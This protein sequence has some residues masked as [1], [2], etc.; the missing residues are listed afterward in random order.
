MTNE[1]KTVLVLTTSF[2]VNENIGAGIHVLG[3]CKQLVK[4]GWKVHVLAP[5]H[6]RSKKFEV[7]EGI[8]VKRFSYF[9]PERY[10]KVA[11]GSGM[12]NNLKESTLAKIQLPF[13]FLSFLVNAIIY[14]KKCDIVHAHWFPAG[15]I[16]VFVKKIFN[17]KL[18][19]MMHHP[20]KKNIIYK[21]ILKNT[22][23]L[24]ANS[25]YVLKRTDEIFETK[26]KA[27]LPVPIDYNQFK[28]DSDLRLIRRKHNIPDDFIF[29]F[30]AGRFINWKGFEYLIEAI[31]LL[32]L[33][34]SI[35]NISLKIAGQGPNFKKYQDLINEKDIYKYVELIGYIPNS[36]MPN[37]YNEAD[38][39]VIPSIIDENGETEGFGVVSLE[40]NA[41]R[42]PV[43]GSKVGGIVDV[44]KDGENGFLVEQKN[45]EDLA[46]KL[47]KLI[48]NR[49]QREK[50]GEIGCE[51]VKNKFNWEIVGNKISDVYN[52][53]I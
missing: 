42:T 17:M 11:Y 29:I 51:M 34:Y 10:Q 9:F 6:V 41:C 39:F 22:D 35:L 36:E 13:F 32:V 19:L 3:K 5:S 50:M 53:L 23:F 31:N 15:L 24:F 49:S 7:I 37:Y 30:S 14:G 18:V 45:A 27:I 12:P 8:N 43:V 25:S 4:N 2:P 20:H 1:T 38:I 44:I 48:M 52:D 40:A 33:D 28:P 21:L 47:A 46:E 26:R 16:G